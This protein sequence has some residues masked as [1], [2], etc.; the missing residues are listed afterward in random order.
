M[1][2]SGYLLRVLERLAMFVFACAANGSPGRVLQRQV[3][4]FAIRGLVLLPGRHMP[5][6]GQLAEGFVEQDFE[7]LGQR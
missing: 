3:Q 4:R 7:L 6:E 1:S 2:V 5:R